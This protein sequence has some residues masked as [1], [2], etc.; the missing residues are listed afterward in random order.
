MTLLDVAARLAH[1]RFRLDAKFAAPGDGITALFGPSGSGKS[2]LLSVLAGLKRCDGYVRLGSR[3]LADS[4][5]HLH[6]APH[7]RGIG[8]VFQDAR[9]FPHLTARANI[10]YAWKRAPEKGA[11][12]YLRCRPLLRYHGAA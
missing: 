5:S 11:S 7:Q 2:T 4:G 12:R 10:A 1:G 8:V 9:L 3:A 6:L